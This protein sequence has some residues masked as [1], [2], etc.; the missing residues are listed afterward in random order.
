MAN[1]RNPGRVKPKQLYFVWIHRADGSYWGGIKNVNALKAHEIVQQYMLQGMQCVVWSMEAYWRF[2]TI[3]ANNRFNTSTYRFKFL[4]APLLY[5]DAATVN[6]QVPW[7][8][9]VAF[10]KMRGY[11]EEYP[12]YSGAIEI[13]TTIT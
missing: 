9:V 10:V 3:P 5:D 2:P 11:N 12:D 8:R 4:V 13:G 7:E 6:G 1:Y